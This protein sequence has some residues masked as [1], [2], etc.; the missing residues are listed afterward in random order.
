LV[1]I[2]SGLLCIIKDSL[3]SKHW[4]EQLTRMDKI[5]SNTS[6][7]I[8]TASGSRVWDGVLEPKIGAHFDASAVCQMG[9]VEKSSESCSY[10][11]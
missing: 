7:T 2:I 3:D 8:V 6:L 9:R 5:Y 11:T 4:I 1:V 10:S